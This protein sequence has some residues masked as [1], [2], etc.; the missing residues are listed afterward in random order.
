[1]DRLRPRRTSGAWPDTRGQVRPKYRKWPESDR[2]I[3]PIRQ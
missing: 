1:M 3:Q 2:K